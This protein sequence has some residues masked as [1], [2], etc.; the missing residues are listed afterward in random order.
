MTRVDAHHHLWDLSRRPQTWLNPPE[1]APVHR[2]FTLRDYASAAAGTGIGR[3]VLVQV[4]ADAEETRE[5]LALAARSETVAAVVGWA[6]LTR[7]DL[8][9]ELAALAASPG[10]ELLR[11]IRHLVQ[12]ES[13]PRWLARD[14]VR[15]GLRQVAA[16]G[17]AYDLLV[18]PHQ[19]P[20][21]I[22]TVRAVPEL[23]F[24]L[25]HLAKPPIASGEL[26]PWAGLIR[27]LA[28][29][30]NVTAKLSGLITEAAWDDWDAAALRPYVDVAL[31]AFGPRRLMFG[32]DWPVCLLAGSLPLWTETVSALL[33]DAGLPAA[34]REAVFRNTATRV[35]HLE[36]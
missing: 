14:D 25:D 20:T 12:G 18:L 4:L 33:A 10:G 16:A 35:Y 5:F 29:E 23:T 28:A 9:D 27:E 13:D 26:E 3:S 19:L 36:G 21:A 6:D 2:D 34:D 8:A 17:L 11:G 22:E 24:V 15:R 1:M 7:P 31:D 30:P 32:S